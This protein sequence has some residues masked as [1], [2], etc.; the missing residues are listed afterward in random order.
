MYISK[1]PDKQSRS[2]GT[3]PIAA[4]CWHGRKVFPAGVAALGRRSVREGLVNPRDVLPAVNRS[5]SGTFFGK[6]LTR[7]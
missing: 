7:Y 3:E 1:S 2:I 5:L 4:I 6:W